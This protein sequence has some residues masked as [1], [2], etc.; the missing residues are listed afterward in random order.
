MSKNTF[1]EGFVWGTACASY[2]CEGGWDAD[3]KGRNIWDDFCHDT[4][5]NHVVNDDTGD[6]A[7]DVY[8]RFKEDVALMKQLGLKVYRF[9][10]SWARVMPTGR[11]EINEAGLK[12]YDELIDELLANG[13]EPWVTLYHWDLPSAL[14]AKG[15]WLNREIV[16]AFEEYATVIA[17]RFSG[18]VKY[19]MTIN[20]PQCVV[21]LGY[22]AGE[23][24]PGLKLPLREVQR[25]MLHTVLAHG[26]GMKAIKDNSPAGV[27][28]GVVPCGTLSYPQ[29]PTEKNIK[30]AYDASFKLLEDDFSFTFNIFTDAAVFH[31]Y[32][33]D[34]PAYLRESIAEIPQ[35]DW[36]KVMKPDFIGINVYNGDEVDEEG[37][38]VKRFPGFPLT[39]AKWPVTPEVMHYGMTN[40]YKR[41]GLPL[42]ITENGVSGNDRVFMD[43]AVHDADRVDFLHM[44]LLEL[45]KSI[46]EGTPIKGY[47]VWSFLDNFE[48]SRGY[49]ERFGIVYV[50]YTTQ[51]RTLKDSA[52]W[53]AD[54]IKTNGGNL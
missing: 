32:D 27:Q 50:D 4:G 30:A 26:V 16:D 28:V 6:V 12:F 47:L 24:A 11:G 31:K 41:Y 23:H 17:K 13:I 3:G 54:V 19:Y 1:P 29:K 43:G 22:Y 40:M 34:A 2:Q 51:K 21:G 35:S 20:E 44:Y 48:W 18:R 25:C 7:C 46:D 36:D 10:I 42:Y 39:A 15:G 8:H 45:K 5:K 53:Y 9:S 33:D 52:L 38:P 49:D 37:K 14:Q